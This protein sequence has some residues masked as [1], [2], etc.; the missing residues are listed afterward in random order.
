MY[1]DSNV[2]AD[3]G[4]TLPFSCMAPSSNFFVVVVGVVESFWFCRRW[5]KTTSMTISDCKST[6]DDS[7]SD[8]EDSIFP[9]ESCSG[10]ENCCT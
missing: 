1:A 6:S 4:A 7:S 9:K 5:N 10:D 3:N 2:H 8:N